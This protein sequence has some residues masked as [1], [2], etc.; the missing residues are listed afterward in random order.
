MA[1]CQDLVDAVYAVNTTLGVISL[2]QQVDAAV[3]Q[4]IRD[5]VENISLHLGQRLPHRDLWKDA[6]AKLVESIIT[7]GDVVAERVAQQVQ[8]DLGLS[9]IATSD[10]PNV[11]PL[12]LSKD[13]DTPG[14][15]GGS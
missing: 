12:D 11:E 2:Q 3:L 1:D 14:I 9:A 7:C 8:A 4:E 15:I 6:L 5:K 10:I 13:I